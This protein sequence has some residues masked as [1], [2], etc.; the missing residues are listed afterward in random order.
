MPVV[1]RHPVAGQLMPHA[2]TTGPGPGSC[3]W[4][5]P[6][7]EA[8]YTLIELLAVV[9]LLG[10]VA[11]AG[12]G[13]VQRAAQPD[14]VERARGMLADW[15]TDLRQDRPVRLLLTS[16]GCG[17]EDAD[18][19]DSCTLRFPDGILRWR[20]GQGH[21]L[22]TLACDAHGWSP[23]CQVEVQHGDLRFRLERLGLSGEWHVVPA[24]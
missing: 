1:R 9:M 19:N 18:G 2:T 3:G 7:P 8:G 15:F 16:T 13:M 22:T 12:G 24:P 23:D 5:R 17:V 4:R 21:D 11:G 20:D 14:P 6:G 10:L